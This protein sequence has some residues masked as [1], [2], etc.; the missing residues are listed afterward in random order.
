MRRLLERGGGARA[1]REAGRRGRRPKLN[2]RCVQSAVRTR[3]GGSDGSDGGVLARFAE[4]SAGLAEQRGRVWAFLFGS[5]RGRASREFEM[6]LWGDVEQRNG[7]PARVCQL[8]NRI[9]ESFGFSIG[10]FI[11]RRVRQPALVSRH[12]M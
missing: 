12:D 11:S 3:G 4:H 9:F 6:R 1:T 2:D 5:G 7:L 8:G 10:G